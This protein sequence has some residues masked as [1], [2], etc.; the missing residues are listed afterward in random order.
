M[1]PHRNLSPH[2]FVT[3]I[4]LLRR[5]FPRLDDPV[6]LVE[7]GRILVNGA[8]CWN[9]QARVRADASLRVL[10]R[11]PLRGTRKLAY[12][13]DFFDIDVRGAVALDLGAAAG[14][15]TQALLDA[16]ARHVYAV[17][18]GIGQLRGWLRADPRVTNL[19]RTNLAQL[20]PLLISETADIVTIDLSYLAVADAVGQ[21]DT[22]LLAPGAGLVALIKPTFELHSATLADRPDDVR[23]AVERAAKSLCQHGWDVLGEVGSPVLGAHGAVEWLLYARRTTG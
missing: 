2:R 1:S 18:A 21:L 10:H 6:A 14:G 12:A 15:F 4:S 17:D 8:P 9:P 20:S 5:R 3:V 22:G 13:L 11:K 19:E 16:G 23:L 7:S